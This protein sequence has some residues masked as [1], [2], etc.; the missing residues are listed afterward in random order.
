MTDSSPRM[1]A[2]DGLMNGETEPVAGAPA[3][4]ERPLAMPD[5]GWRSP[6]SARSSCRRQPAPAAHLVGDVPAEEFGFGRHGYDAATHL[7]RARAQDIAPVRIE[8][9]HELRRSRQVEGVADQAHFGSPAA[10]HTGAT[11][12]TQCDWASIAGST[13]GSW[14]FGSGFCSAGVS[15]SGMKVD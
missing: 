3:P 8:Q 14:T 2:D 7:L 15:R 10:T 13:I 12:V 1:Q 4:L 5:V 6:A 9:R 11:S